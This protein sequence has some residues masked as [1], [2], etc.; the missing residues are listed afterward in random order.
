MIAFVIGYFVWW[1]NNRFFGKNLKMARVIATTL[2]VISVIYLLLGS[3][4][5]LIEGV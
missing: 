4:S 5:Y 2:V 1:I 3:L